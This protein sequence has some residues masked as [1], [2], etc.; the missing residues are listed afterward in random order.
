MKRIVLLLICSIT[1]FSCQKD[2]LDIEKIPSSE[3][4]EPTFDIQLDFPS[5][6]SNV[7]HILQVEYEHKAAKGE[8]TQLEY[9]EERLLEL[10]PETAYV[11]M[12]TSYQEELSRYHE[13]YDR[14]QEEMCRYNEHHGI[15][16]EL[17]EPV[18]WNYTEGLEEEERAELLHLNN[19]AKSGNLLSQSDLP[20]LSRRS[21]ARANAHPAFAAIGVIAVGL[22]YSGYWA[23]N[24]LDHALEKEN[25]Y[26]P[27]RETTGDNAD[28]FF[29]MY[30]SMHLRRYLTSM[31][32]RLIMNEV[33]KRGNNEP[34][35]RQMD[36]HNNSVGREAKY[37]TFR[38]KYFD[39]WKKW[40][41]RV[42]DFV[43]GHPTN[44]I[45]M[46]ILH[47]WKTNPPTTDSQALAAI[48][49]EPLNGSRYAYWNGVNRDIPACWGRDCARGY[50][51]NY[52][53][54]R[55]EPDPD[56]DI[57]ADCSF[58]ER[59]VNGQCTPL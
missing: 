42:R 47:Q 57:C 56:S 34:R 22:G 13:A 6:P 48:R 37:S 4:S 38:G 54:R 18:D 25:E 20:S 45:P 36:L 5:F 41:R 9:L 7:L 32:S 2:D 19:L 17:E 14:Y 27:V 59:C 53:T 26:Y 23:I 31:G 21:S 16:Y 58:D 52:L 51:C 10:Y 8:V 28:A 40:A 15:A 46:D 11:G 33:E 24:S 50:R 29:H 12:F 1:F 30:I 39:G 3:P 43:N 35:D 44:G 55:C 49:S